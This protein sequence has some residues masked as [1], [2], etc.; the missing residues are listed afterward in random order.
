M[1]IMHNMIHMHFHCHNM[2]LY[3][4]LST[5]IMVCLIIPFPTSIDC[6]APGAL[7]N[8]STRI[9]L[10]V[11]LSCPQM[12]MGVDE[13]LLHDYTPLIPLLILMLIRVYLGAG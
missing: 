7:Q 12:P 13:V 5:L 9:I 1:N 10:L 3:M 8:W 11:V 4:H 6:L 2:N